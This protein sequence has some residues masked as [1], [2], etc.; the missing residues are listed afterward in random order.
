[1]SR[2]S[3]ARGGHEEGVM[4]DPEIGLCASCRHARTV[5]TPRSRFWRC[6]RSAT[7]PR[8]PKYPRLPM[9]ECPGYEP[10]EA[11]TPGGEPGVSAD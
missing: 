6:A 7:D 3:S 1:M 5:D 4:R 11:E 9:L 2:E 8:Y 10:A